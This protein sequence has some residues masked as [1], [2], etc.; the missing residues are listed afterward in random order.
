MIK[1]IEKTQA[2]FIKSKGVNQ[3]AAFID[4]GLI[5]LSLIIKS[6]KKFKEIKSKLTALN[7]E[8]QKINREANFKKRYFEMP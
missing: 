1:S 2:D 6:Y 3:T 4:C 8:F 5:R 7:K